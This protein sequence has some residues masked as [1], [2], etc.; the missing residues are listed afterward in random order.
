[1]SK[2]YNPKSKKKRKLTSLN[3]LAI[4]NMLNKEQKLEL[5]E[6]IAKVSDTKSFYARIASELLVSPYD[7]MMA[8]IKAK[9]LFIKKYVDPDFD[10]YFPEIP[11]NQEIKGRSGI[12]S[13]YCDQY[14]DYDLDVTI[15][16]IFDSHYQTYRKFSNFD[17]FNIGENVPIGFLEILLGKKALSFIRENEYKI[18]AHQTKNKYGDGDAFG[19]GCHGEYGLKEEDRTVT[20]LSFESK[21]FIVVETN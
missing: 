12:I 18:Y 3:T 14:L 16:G 10:N 2:D 7:E 21:M 4:M 13:V 11:V 8:R 20:D 1:M 6:E 15:D 9:S 19:H 5:L 17:F